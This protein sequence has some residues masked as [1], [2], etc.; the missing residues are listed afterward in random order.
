MGVRSGPG[1]PRSHPMRMISTA[2]LIIPY[3]YMPHNKKKNPGIQGMSL[4]KIGRNG[5][6]PINLIG[7]H[8]YCPLFA[9]IHN[10]FCHAAFL[11]PRILCPIF[12]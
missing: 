11:K 1:I 7:D 8:I 3:K 4:S 12:S 6:I 9:T 2:I 10:P 5:V